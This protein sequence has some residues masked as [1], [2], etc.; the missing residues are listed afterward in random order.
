M[1]VEGDAVSGKSELI[2]I[3]CQIM[4]HEFREAGDDPDKPY[5]LKGALTGETT[6]KIK[7]QTL[8]TLFNLN[9]GNKL[10]K[11]SDEMRDLLQNLRHHY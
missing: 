5:I 10:Y 2:R 4:E 1:V 11:L 8:H 9:F 3:L 7:G 6:T